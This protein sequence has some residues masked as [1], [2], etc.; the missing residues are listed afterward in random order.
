[1][2]GYWGLADRT[3]QALRQNP[4]HNDY[5]DPVYATGDIVK[6]GP[7][8]NYLFLG[9]RDNMVKSRGYRIELGEIEAALQRHP[10]VAEAAAVAVPDEEIGSRILAFVALLEGGDLPEGDLRRHAA[11]HLARYMV[12]E[13]IL[14]EPVL[15]KTSTGKIDR[16]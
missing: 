9:R 13:R 14:V 16:Q 2:K 3:A 15:P 4:L 7:D 6:L 8:G 12:P 5:A 11:G 10:A 1:M